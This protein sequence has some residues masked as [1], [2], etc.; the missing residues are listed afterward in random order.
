MLLNLLFTNPLIF[1]VVAMGMVVAI[2]IHEFAHALV[3]TWLGDQTAKNAGRLTLNPASHL[4]L[5]G[6]LMLLLAGFGWGKP[7][8][9]NPYNL[10]YQRWGATMVACAGPASNLLLVVIGGIC[11]RIFVSTGVLAET[12]LLVYFLEY[13][14]FINLMLAVFNLIPIPPLDG[15]KLLFGILDAPKYDHI[16]IW[17]TT[18]GPIVLIIFIILDSWLNLNIFQG[19]FMFFVNLVYKILF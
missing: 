10:R 3:S 5:V 13:I 14:V 11:L 9:Y 12:N 4:S 16:K 1:L 6:S 19:I 15:S 2:T 8:P 17:L 18:R 7:V